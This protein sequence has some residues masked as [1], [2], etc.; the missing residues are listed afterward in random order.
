MQLNFKKPKA[1]P[2]ERSS[3]TIVQVFVWPQTETHPYLWAD[4]NIQFLCIISS[5]N[6]GSERSNG[7]PETVD[8]GD[9][10]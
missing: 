1:T 5:C 7:H 9:N 3:C 10:V 6:A 4:F 8:F 2:L